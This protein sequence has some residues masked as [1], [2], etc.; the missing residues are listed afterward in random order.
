MNT[1]QT[2]PPVAPP[3]EENV[4]VIPTAEIHR[5]LTTF[6]GFLPVK[7]NPAAVS[8]LQTGMETYLRR[9][10]AEQDPS[11]KQLIPYVLLKQEGNYYSYRRAKSGGEKRLHGR[12][13]LGI[14][15]HINQDDKDLAHGIARELDEEITLPLGQSVQLRLE[16]FL[17][18][19]S[20][21][22]GQ[23]HLGVVYI[24][25]LGPGKPPLSAEPSLQDLLPRS[26]AD[27]LASLEDFESWSKILIP[28]LT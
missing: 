23:V 26:R 18:D 15:G 8:L 20:N 1:S 19:D 24:L 2:S 11:Y 14:G 28:H 7:D 17:N 13:S 9:S 6:Q 5:R 22:V 21:S 16:G 3:S 25:E 12:L 27:L 10:L 4:L